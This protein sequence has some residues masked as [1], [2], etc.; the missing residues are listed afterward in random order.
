MR[1]MFS[2]LLLAILMIHF[3]GIDSLAIAQTAKRRK[4][5]AANQP[6][7]FKS[8]RIDRVQKLVTDNKFLEASI[9]LYQLKKDKRLDQAQVSYLLGLTLM[10]QGYQQVAAMQFIDVIRRGKNKYVRSALNRLFIIADLLGEDSI[11]HYAVKKIA[12][13][14]PPA[15]ALDPF[16][17]RQ[18][19][20]FSDNGNVKGAIESFRKISSKSPY[21]FL[22]QYKLYLSYLELNQPQQ[23]LAIA[24]R[25]LRMANNQNDRHLMLLAIARA[26]YQGKDWEK[27][28]RYYKMV[29]RDSLYWPQAL[30]ELSWAQL[31][32]ARFRSVVGTLQT[33]HSPFFEN[34]YNPETFI[35]RSIVYV[36]ICRFDEAEKTLMVF[37]KVFGGYVKKARSFYL[38]HQGQLRAYWDEVRKASLRLEGKNSQ[39]HDG[40]IPYPIMKSIVTSGEIQKLLKYI[41]R[42]NQE[43]ARWESDGKLKGHSIFSYGRKVLSRRLQ[44]A[45]NQVAKLAQYALERKIEDWTDLQEQ[46]QFVM[47]EVVNGKKEALKAIISGVSD[48]Q[49]DLDH[50]KQREFYVN[51][52][53]EYWPVDTEYWLDEIGNYHYMGKQQCR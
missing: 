36:Y 9:E 4:Q 50:D 21:Y 33:L 38:S 22:G 52:G 35:V 40:Q 31:R 32:A 41:I 16:Y 24:E 47:Y 30:F 34:E 18:G 51:N 45:Q 8:D 7:T 43:L 23:A 13:D 53:Y 3:G 39:S 1:K 48:K 26:Y 2:I 15:M 11:I 28:I 5:I 44:V 49:S 25:M 14:D 29:P 17:F 37:D 10:E 46:A 19:E 42:V 6:V 20:Y 12:G 27:A